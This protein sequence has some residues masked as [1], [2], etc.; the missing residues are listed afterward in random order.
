MNAVPADV[1]AL[2][3]RLQKVIERH[4]LGSLD[5]NPYGEATAIMAELGKKG[6]VVLCR[7]ERDEHGAITVSIALC[8]VE[9]MEWT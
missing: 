5:D 1:E 9:D 4:I 7:I 3:K 8:S 2:A 6:Y